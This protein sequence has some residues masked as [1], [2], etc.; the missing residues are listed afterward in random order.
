MNKKE[1]LEY[2]IVELIHDYKREYNKNLALLTKPLNLNS[3]PIDAN[4]YK[5]MEFYRG[6]DI[7]DI[8]GKDKVESVSKLID[9]IEAKKAS[10]IN[11][12]YIM[13]H[14]LYVL[15]LLDEIYDE[16]IKE[17]IDDTYIKK[18]IANNR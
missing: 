7:L 12:G 16:K 9:I 18:V 17:G 2:G 3:E 5:L 8:E 1:I 11:V 15:E 13:P 14:I 6:A 10:G 4:Y